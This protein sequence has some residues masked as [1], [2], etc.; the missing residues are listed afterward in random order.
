MWALNVRT[1]TRRLKPQFDGFR[2]YARSQQVSR[3]AGLCPVLL[4]PD[5][6]IFF[7]MKVK[8]YMVDATRRLPSVELQ[9]SQMGRYSGRI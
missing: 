1:H 5:F 2:W 6:T 4:H 9:L 7:Q 8:K 3:H